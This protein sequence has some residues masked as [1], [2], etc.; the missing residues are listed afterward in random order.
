MGRVSQINMLQLQGGS[1]SCPCRGRLPRGAPGSKVSRKHN[2]FVFIFLY[3][4][5]LL[6]SVACLLTLLGKGLALASPLA[7]IGDDKNLP[8]FWT[9]ST[10]AAN[11][12]SPSHKIL[13]L[14]IILTTIFPFSNISPML[15][16][17]SVKFIMLL[18]STRNLWD[19]F[20]REA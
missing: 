10:V 14:A 8:P 2:F 11:S 15:L 16:M 20:L 4:R 1:L 19:V 9:S 13:V 12:F 7:I 17:C 5:F 6:L 3:P 18:R